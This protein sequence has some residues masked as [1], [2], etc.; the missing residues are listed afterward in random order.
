[1]PTTPEQFEK[2]RDQYLEQRDTLKKTI[3]INENNSVETHNML[4]DHTKVF[5]DTIDKLEKDINDR[6]KEYKESLDKIKNALELISSAV[7]MQTV[8]ESDLNQLKLNI[9]N[10]LSK[11]KE[12]NN[13][14]DKKIE[15]LNK[16][17]TR[18]DI[19]ITDLTRDIRIMAENMADMMGKKKYMTR[20]EDLHQEKM[21]TSI[22]DGTS[23]LL[24]KPK[25]TLPNV[26]LKEQIRKAKELLDQKK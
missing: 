3:E 1:M 22:R 20:A 7:D 6:D 26:T 15:L 4:A 23:T 5:N 17:Q 19:S 8:N 25:T 16:S 12:D 21:N 18:M 2:L 11:Q 10:N 24:Y 9:S 14:L 13:K